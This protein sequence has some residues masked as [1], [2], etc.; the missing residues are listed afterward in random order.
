MQHPHRGKGGHRDLLRV[1]TSDVSPYLETDDAN[2]YL[3]VSWI[4]ESPGL[5]WTLSILI[6]RITTPLQM[7]KRYPIETAIIPRD[8]DPGISIMRYLA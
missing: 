8:R 1:F 6:L 5:Q 3:P 7:G 4:D 2:E